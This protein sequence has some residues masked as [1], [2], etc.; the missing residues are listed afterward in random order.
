M[1]IKSLC[2]Q[3]GLVFVNGS[4]LEKSEHNSLQEQILR[5]DQMHKVGKKCGVLM[6]TY[7][8]RTEVKASAWHGSKGCCSVYNN[9]HPA[10]PDASH[11][12]SQELRSL[13]LLTNL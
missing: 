4:T 1:E 5:S 2:I 9:G 8:G 6:S 7:V 3:L 12:I 10:P 13:T 11:A